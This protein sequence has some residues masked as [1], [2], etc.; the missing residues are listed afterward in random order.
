MD[1]KLRQIVS[2]AAGTY[3]IVTDNSQVANIEAE[4]KM[5]LFFI[6]MEKGPVNMLFKFAKGDSLGFLSVFGK[7]TRLQEKK[8]NFSISTCLDALSAGPIAVINLRA[9]NEN[10]KSGLVG[11][12]PNIL[13]SNAVEF[14]YSNLFNT[15][16]FW[17]P[18][19]KNMVA[20]LEIEGANLLNFG[21][22]GNNNLSIFVTFAKSSDVLAITSEGQNTLANCSLTID[23]Y[24]AIDPNML[25]ENTFVNV[26]VFN[27]TFNPVTVGTN[28]FYGHLFN[29]QGNLDFTRIEELIDI[30]E[31]GFAT[32]FTGSLIPGLVS[33]NDIDISIDKVIN[34]QYMNI[35]LLAYINDELFEASNKFLLDVFADEFYDE[36]GDAVNTNLLSHIT[37]VA[38]TTVD[39]VY[40]LVTKEANVAPLAANVINYGCVKVDTNKF[41]G[42]FE[43]GLR[44][45]DILKGTEG[46]VKIVSIDIIDALAIIGD[47]T[48]TKVQ[49]IC[50]GSVKFEDTIVPAVIGTGTV[51]NP[52]F[53]AKTTSE[54][55]KFN[56][57]TKTGLIKPFALNAYVPRSTQFTDGTSEKQNEI[58]NMMI[59]PGIVK[60]IKSA[61]GIRYVVDC[62][63]SFVEPSYKSQFGSLMVSLDQSNKFVRAIINE[64]F[65]EDLQKS[66]NPMFKQTPTGIFDWSYVPEG[67]NKT[68]S[69]KLLTKFSLGAE[70]CFFFGPGN[71]VGSITKPLTGLIS[72]LFYNKR[73][74]FDVVA[75]ATGYVDGIAELESAIDDDERAYCE[76]FGYNPIIY[77]GGGNTIYGNLTG[78]KAK[79][80]QQQI[81][82]SEL[83]AYI[84]ESLYNLAKGESFK[85]GNY[86]DY[87]RTETETT[88]FMNG[89]AL[90]GAVNANPVV[91][92]NASNNTPEIA[93]QKIKLIHIE[94]TPVD[95]LEKVVFDLQIN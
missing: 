40:P 4:S 21:N 31:A 2:K 39:V 28:Q 61:T 20:P 60:G 81:H 59:S 68:Y 66:S 50:S 16:N 83:L 46:K 44:V 95:S 92:C 3:F 51:E 41:E 11:M 45:G 1:T 74:A 64:P 23:E 93:K 88:N 15:N 30:S 76:R 17:A 13:D 56:L 73:Y 67:G 8:G 87:L 25:L 18:Q 12:N 70:M 58:L 6:N 48:Y 52:Q 43:Q 54:V 78:Q 86:D 85:K 10:D 42:S 62:F 57:F 27:N 80:A 65:I 36:T 24:P 34:Q 26:Y 69:S 94:Y 82:N 72:N 91:I 9:F 90:V 77:F 53:P 32:K 49:F 55:T 47:S 35:G 84:K 33:E 63:K 89:L 38:L 75:N 19:P 37:P 14:E 22:I 29:A 71:I 7:T 79:T 5:R